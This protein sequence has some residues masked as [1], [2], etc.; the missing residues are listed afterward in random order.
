MGNSKKNDRPS[1][2]D[3]E[4]LPQLVGRLG[5]DITALIDTKIN[6][7]KVEIK[8]DISA[9][10]SYITGIIIGA[11]VAIVGFALCNVAVAFFISSLFQHTDLSQPV[12][13]ALGFIITA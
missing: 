10:T 9:Y 6:L 13:Y 1:E 5:Q 4:S 3:A 8:E 7:L 12:K 2:R 11:V